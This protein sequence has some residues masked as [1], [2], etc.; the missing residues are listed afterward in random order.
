MNHEVNTQAYIAELEASNRLLGERVSHLESQREAAGDKLLHEPIDKEKHPQL[1]AFQNSTNTY[2]QALLRL[3]Y[4]P[5]VEY[6]H[7]GSE[8]AIGNFKVKRKVSGQFMSAQR[9]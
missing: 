5:L 3:L 7:N 6:D 4:E 2:G 9:S 1:L 8:R